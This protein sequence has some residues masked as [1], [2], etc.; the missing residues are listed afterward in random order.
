MISIDSWIAHDPDPVTR[1][2]LTE[3]KQRAEDGDPVA[4]AELDD[5]FSGLLE[6]GT[7]GLRGEMAGGPFRMNRAV[8]R[9]A[10]A[11]LVEFL[12]D[13]VGRDALI[14]IGYDARYNSH[15][16]AL[17]T[18]A[19]AT[20]A[21]ARA[22]IFPR[23]L[24]TPLLAWAVR[25]LN[26]DA[27]VMV[28]ASH[29]PPRD[30]GYKVYLGGRAVE[31]EARGIQIVPPFDSQIAAKIAATPPADEIPLASTGWGLIDESVVDA[32]LE[33]TKS[34]VTPEHASDLKIVHTSMHGVGG[35]TMRRVLEGAGFVNVH[36]V[37]Q[38]AEPDPSFPTVSFPNP[39]EPGALDLAIAE[40]KRVGADL[41][42]ANDPDADRC[43]V[44]IPTS[45]GWR[46]L[47]GDEIGSILGEQI[48]KIGAITGGT[49]ASS[50]VS[51]RLLREIAHS[52]GL[53]HETTLTGFK[54]IARAPEIIYGYEEAIGFCVDPDGVKDKDGL[55]AGLLFAYVTA[56]LQSRD[57]TIEDQLDHLARAHGVY[58]TAPVT[59]RVSDLALMPAT[60]A[61]L[62]ANSPTVLA[63]LPVTEVS[64]LTEGSAELPPTDAV[65][66]LNEKGD[67]AVVRPSGT[68]PKVKCYLE[69]IE[70]VVD[71]VETA[72]AEA[73]R[74][75]ALL[76]KDMS[77]ALTLPA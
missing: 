15:D 69:V 44:A 40:A 21:G 3:L 36:E 71:S 32:Y 68:E 74:R 62:R 38:Q 39:E 10:A 7:A 16:F 65:V 72:R 47:N 22:L 52:H 30:N 77:A 53:K 24:P 29:N 27:G 13:T 66:L 42:I 58:L 28:T 60:M 61:H 35:E 48:A 46:Q 25:Y 9:K 75:M 51:S 2:E 19:V 1:S 8:V 17:D 76:Q 67:R 11:G 23:H 70:P 73:S 20:A 43:S 45:T 56:L 55:T 34:L 64:D 49:F 33:R 5:R 6:F 14:V 57:Q 41:V 12:Q 18:A 59:I 63:G 54:W 26:A 37:P 31:P 50:V 4:R